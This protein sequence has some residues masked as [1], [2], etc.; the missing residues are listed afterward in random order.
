M[1][2]R[3]FLLNLEIQ[4]LGIYAIQRIRIDLIKLHFIVLSSNKL[5]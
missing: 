2:G 5:L 4:R 3:H 1:D